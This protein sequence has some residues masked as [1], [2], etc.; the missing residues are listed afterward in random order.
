MLIV[1]IEMSNSKLLSAGISAILR[2]NVV[3]RRGGKYSVDDL[4]T[5]VHLE[6]DRAMSGCDGQSVAAAGPIPKQD[7][8]Q[9]FALSADKFATKDLNLD[10]TSLEENVAAYKR[11]GFE[12][13]PHNGWRKIAAYGLGHYEDDDSIDLNGILR[14]DQAHEEWSI[15][16]QESDTGRAEMISKEGFEPVSGEEV[17][18]CSEQSARHPGSGQWSS[19][20]HP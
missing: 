1:A 5:K 14:T 12:C 7:G 6:D 16:H 17:Q 19:S 18:D 15:S 13:K 20:T 3:L 9:D 2:K 4:L 11:G 8:N 10:S